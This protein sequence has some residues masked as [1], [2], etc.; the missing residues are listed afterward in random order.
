MAGWCPG[1][2]TRRGWNK[3]AKD[4][5]EI[6]LDKCVTWRQA[7]SPSVEEN[8]GFPASGDDSGS[9]ESLSR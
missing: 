1:D 2:L 5:S 6:W 4:K 8:G 7:E 9:Q 3:S